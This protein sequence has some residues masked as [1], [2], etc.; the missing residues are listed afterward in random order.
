MLRKLFTTIGTIEVL[1]PG[2]LINAAERIALDNPEECELQPWVIPEAR[3]EGLVILGTMWRGD[4]SYSSF[5]KF[6]GIIG[7][8]A[9]FYPRTYVDYGAELAYTNASTCEWR[10]WVYAGTRLV[11][12]LY[13]MIAL[14]E[15]R[16]ES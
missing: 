15:L 14:E 16:R 13:V 8:L 12:L 10:P 9:L 7:L 6:L 1:A 3:L 5:K 2:A 11:G 4:A